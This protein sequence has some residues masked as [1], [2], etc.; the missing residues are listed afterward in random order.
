MSYKN[1]IIMSYHPT[2]VEYSGGVS[3]IDFLWFFHRVLWSMPQSSSDKSDLCSIKCFNEMLQ[4]L[5]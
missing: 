5:Q 2:F 1:V 3:T 4:N